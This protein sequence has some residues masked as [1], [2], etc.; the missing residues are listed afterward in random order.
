M[1]WSRI[2]HVLLTFLI[3]MSLFLSFQLW[4]A[5]G[6]L[7]EPASGGSGSVVPSSLVDRQ[8]TEVFSPSQIIWHGSS[9]GVKLEANPFDLQEWINEEFSQVSYGD[10][11]SPRRVSQKEY[12]ERLASGE[13]VEFIFNGPIPFGLFEDAF[14][15]LA[16]DY[17]N[18]TFTHLYINRNDPSELGFYD[19]NNEIDYTVEDS[20]F[21]PEALDALLNNANNQFHEVQAFDVSDRF[22]YLPVDSIEVDYHDYLVARLPNNLYVNQFFADTSEVDSRRTGSTIRY[23]DLTTEVRIND[24]NNT[25]T[26]LRQLNNMGQMS[27]NDRLMSSFEELRQ[28]ENWTE[29]IH[30]RSYTPSTNEVAFQRHIQGYPV[31]SHQQQESMVLITVV[32]NGLNNLRLPLRVVQTPLSLSGEAS[33]VLASGPEVI[34]QLETTEQGLEIVD[35]ITVGLSWIESDEDSRVVHFEPNWYVESDNVWYELERFILL[36]EGA[37]QNGL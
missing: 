17:H 10:I 34:Q 15:D 12:Q 27:F 23:I 21:T 19:Q 18:R 2:K 6:E 35:D 5:G 14:E 22:I 8:I 33:K 30:Y 26:F 25:L 24:S 13:W 4:T 7:R 3:G 9:D 28:I 29:T 11:N 1:T 37:Q 16:A 32:E 36:Q 20:S 31:F